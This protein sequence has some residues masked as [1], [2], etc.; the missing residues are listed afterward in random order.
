MRARTQARACACTLI[1]ESRVARL[2]IDAVFGEIKWHD[3]CVQHV[4][5]ARLTS[6]L[7]H[8]KVKPK[9]LCVCARARTP[10]PLGRHAR[11]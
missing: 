2:K 4:R 11:N 5:L 8:R 10:D 7:R 6:A 3:D 9:E 1:A